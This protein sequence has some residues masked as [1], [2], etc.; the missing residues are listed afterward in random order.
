ME[1]HVQMSLNRNVFYACVSDLLCFI[2]LF[3]LISGSSWTP[4]YLGQTDPVSVF[5]SQQPSWKDPSGCS[6]VGCTSYGSPDDPVNI[7][8]PPPQKKTIYCFL[9]SCSV[10]LF[11]TTTLEFHRWKRVV[12]LFAKFSKSVVCSWEN[13]SMFFCILDLCLTDHW[14]V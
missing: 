5:P 11:N 10:F 7:P 1:T 12:S 2:C 8:T 9:S 3:S 4:T 6:R 13:S 14:E